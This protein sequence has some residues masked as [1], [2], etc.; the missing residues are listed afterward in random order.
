M[1]FMELPH[2]K[3]GQSTERLLNRRLLNPHILDHLLEGSRQQAHGDGIT[4]PESSAE[5]KPVYKLP[6]ENL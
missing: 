5:P 1:G 6:K 3:H 2:M 4:A